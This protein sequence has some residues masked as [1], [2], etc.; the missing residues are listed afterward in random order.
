MILSYFIYIVRIYLFFKIPN[1]ADNDFLFIIIGFRI[2]TIALIW[3]YKKFKVE[4][5]L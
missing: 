4:E 1:I 2:A 3:Q 5:S